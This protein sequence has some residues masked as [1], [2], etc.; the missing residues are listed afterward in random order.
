MAGIQSKTIQ[1][2]KMKKSK[3]IAV[4]CLGFVVVF[5]IVVILTNPLEGVI[6]NQEERN[7]ERFVTNADGVTNTFRQ[8]V[9]DCAQKND[10]RQEEKCMDDVIGEYQIQFGSLIK[11]FGYESSTEQLYQYW[12]ADLDFWF[13]SKK[14]ELQYLES[15]ELLQQELQR[16]SDIRDQSVQERLQLDFAQKVE[17]G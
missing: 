9:E 3:I 1:T 14:A 2:R 6:V 10:Q 5:V 4:G 7:Y 8:P 17:S 15:P 12:K 13:D 16:L 11:L